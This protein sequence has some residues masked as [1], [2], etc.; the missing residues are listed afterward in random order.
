M[1][2]HTIEVCVMNVAGRKQN[3]NHEIQTGLKVVTGKKQHATYVALKVYSQR[4]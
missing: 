4:K 2:L 1:R 3:K